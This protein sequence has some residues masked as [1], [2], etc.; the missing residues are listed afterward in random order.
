MHQGGEIAN[1]AGGN[2]TNRR[3]GTVR[4]AHEVSGRARYR[5]LRARPGPRGAPSAPDTTWHSLAP[6]ILPRATP[7]AA[8]LLEQQRTRRGAA[9]RSTRPA[10]GDA[11]PA[12]RR[13][14]RTPG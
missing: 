11:G 1:A 2:K 13:P 14:G 10:G 3:A 9:A 4:A 6:S 8:R 5:L 7:S 12:R